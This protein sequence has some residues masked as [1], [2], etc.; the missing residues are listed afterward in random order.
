MT[1]FVINATRLTI[2]L[3]SALR[4]SRGLI[5]RGRLW[6]SKSVCGQLSGCHRYERLMA[7]SPFLTNIRLI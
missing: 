4:A 5:P 3:S 2:F 6:S 7:T 1:I